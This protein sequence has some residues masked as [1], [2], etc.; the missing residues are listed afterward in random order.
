VARAIPSR[1]PGDCLAVRAGART[2]RT[3]TPAG[4]TAR[5]GPATRPLMM[6][7]HTLVSPRG[8][9]HAILS[10][11]ARQASM[12][13]GRKSPG[14]SQHQ[15]RIVHAKEVWSGLRISTARR[16]I[17]VLE[18]AGSAMELFRGLIYR[19]ITLV[20]SGAQ[21]NSRAASASLRFTQPCEAIFA[22]SGR[23]LSSRP[24]PALIARWRT[25]TW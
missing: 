18:N 11:I 7:R 14:L 12:G 16:Q 15:R 9:G 23:T 22:D 2:V 24:N 6:K 8:C 3:D 17:P 5:Q 25:Q 4:A 19:T 1:A 20:P 21:S 13:R 10:R